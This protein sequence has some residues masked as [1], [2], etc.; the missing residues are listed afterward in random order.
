MSLTTNFVCVTQAAIA[1][2]ATKLRESATDV[3]EALSEI[4]SYLSRLKDVAVEVRIRYRY[5]LKVNEASVVI[6]QWKCWQGL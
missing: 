2:E 6:K 4:Q 3:Q 5:N 1:E